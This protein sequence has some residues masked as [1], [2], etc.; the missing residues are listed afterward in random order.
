MASLGSASWTGETVRQ[1]AMA[2]GKNNIKITLSQQLARKL[3]VKKHIWFYL[4]LFLILIA[5]SRD[6]LETDNA[7]SER[8][9]MLPL[10]KLT[11][12]SSPI[13]ESEEIIKVFFLK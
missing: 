9:E 12:I 3:L 7:M 1:L 13:F 6:Y 11:L 2:A 5:F 10:K 8:H 4:S